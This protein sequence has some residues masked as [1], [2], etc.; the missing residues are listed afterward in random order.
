[1]LILKP[2]RVKAGERG[3]LC[4]PPRVALSGQIGA[5]SAG[6][7]SYQSA[8]CRTG[9]GNQ[10]QTIKIA[11]LGGT[12]PEGIGLAVQLAAVGHEIVLG[13][14]SADRAAEAASLVEARLDD[15]DFTAIRAAENEF[16]CDAAEL[17]FLTVPYAGQGPMLELVGPSM[18]DKIAVNVI[19]P[20]RFAGGQAIAS[21]PPAGSAAEEAREQCPG[22]RWVAGFHTLPASELARRDAILDADALI[23]GD[24]GEAK[25][26]VI[27]IAN[28]M[29]GIRGVDA[30][31]L[32]AARYLEGA[33]ALLINMNRL[34]KA[35]AALRIT[36]I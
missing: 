14:R 31:P 24:D 19:A 15:T 36:G 30:G 12:G 9:A 35:H 32:S 6:G 34:H 23:C 22:A 28:Q 3:S 10:E 27:A 29:P 17:I 1:M 20:L 18:Q 26:G 13:S 25:S 33:T 8:K 5:S 2:S 16:A 4:L 11:I 21:P 7:E